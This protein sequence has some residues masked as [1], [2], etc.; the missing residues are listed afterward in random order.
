MPDNSAPPA[1]HFVKSW[2]AEP[3]GERWRFRLWAPSA[4]SASVE[5]EGRRVPLEPAG[6][7]WHE[8]SVEAQAEQ[9]YSFLVGDLRVPDPAARAQAGDV[10]GPSRLVDPRDY[11]WSVPWNGR[12]WEEAVIYELHVG[13]FTPEGTFAAAAERLEELAALGVTT[14]ELMPVGQFAGSRGW[15]YDCVLPYAPHNAYGTPDDMKRLVEKAHSLGLMV[16]LDV[17]YNHFGPEGAYLHA[18]APEFFHEEVHTPW[19]AA[20]A[21]DLRPVRDFMIDNALFWLEEYRL[22]GLRLDAV[23]HIHDPYSETELLVELAQRVRA[24]GFDRPIHLTTEDNRNITRLH[25]PEENLYTGEWNDDYHHCIHCLLT[26]EHEFYYLNFSVD[27]LADLCKSLAEGYVEQGQPRKSGTEPP[28]GEPSAELPWSAFVNFNQNHDQIGNRAEGDRLIALGGEEGARIAHCLLLLSPFVP[29]LFM[30]EEYGEWRPFTFFADLHGDLAEAVRTGRMNE[31][32]QFSAFAGDIVPDPIAPQTAAMSRLSWS[33]DHRAN[34]W[35]AL[36]RELLQ[37]RAERVVPLMKSGRA[38]PAEVRRLGDRSLAARWPHEGGT[39]EV[40]ANF[41][42][43]PDEA[44]PSFEPDFV[45]GDVARDRYAFAFR[46][47][48]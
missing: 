29:L 32:K 2:G 35:R 22:D 19:G 20:I 1:R 34:E 18:Y 4:D 23:D 10:H 8:A 9:T 25:R 30:G 16:L 28:R 11:A 48:S 24:H 36:T 41:G 44:P 39:I 40:V 3:D 17:I 37:L 46:T 38:A 15:G 31:F 33:R 7:G 21:Y 45:L 12:A 6:E 14:I 47:G 27:P 26:G 5:I 43:P 42:A 13:T